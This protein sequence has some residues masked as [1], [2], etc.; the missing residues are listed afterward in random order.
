MRTSRS[1]LGRRSPPRAS[2]LLSRP[3][4]IP[5]P[6]GTKGPAKASILN[7]VAQV[8]DKDG[9][10]YVAPAERIAVFDNDGTLWPEQPVYTQFLFGMDRAKA[11]ARAVIRSGKTRSPSSLRWPEI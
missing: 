4:K 2:R 11:V 1:L 5:C 3:P 9:P 6:P 10:G 8:T 7:F